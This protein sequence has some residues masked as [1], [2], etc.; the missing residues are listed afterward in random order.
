MTKDELEIGKFYSSGGEPVYKLED[1][2]TDW[3]LVLHYSTVHYVAN[4][5]FFRLEEFLEAFHQEDDDWW[6]SVFSDDLVFDDWQMLRNK[7]KD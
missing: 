6:D 7:D 2:G 3:V 1:F 5:E 4:P